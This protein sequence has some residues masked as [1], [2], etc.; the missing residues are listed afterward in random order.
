MIQTEKDI[1]F[2]WQDHMRFNKSMLN[3]SFSFHY[4]HISDFVK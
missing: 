2:V 3:V 4:D 1:I